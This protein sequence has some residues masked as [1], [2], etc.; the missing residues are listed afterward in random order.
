MRTWF[1][2]LIL[3]LCAPFAHSQQSSPPDQL[4]ASE[5]RLILAQLYELRSAR[6]QIQTYDQFIAREK[7]Q[8]AKEVALSQRALELERQATRNAED[9]AKLM[10]EKANTYKQ[11]LDA[12][13]KKSGVGCTLKRIF[14]LGIARCGG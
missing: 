2:L 8:D 7:D 1:A 12:T 11:L 13:K 6:L 14:T 4:S 10:E 3:I 9:R 5:L